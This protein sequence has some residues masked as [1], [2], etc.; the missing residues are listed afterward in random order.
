MLRI[1]VWCIESHLRKCVRVSLSQPVYGFVTITPPK[2]RLTS[3]TNLPQHSKELD[4][5][6]E[7]RRTHTLLN[8]WLQKGTKEVY[9][10]KK[11]KKDIL[12]GRGIYP[13]TRKLSD[14]PQS[15]IS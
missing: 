7:T 4:V 9:L 15:P 12:R 13:T 8:I 11:K 14:E 2:G 10:M 1:A 3:S 5:K 6:T